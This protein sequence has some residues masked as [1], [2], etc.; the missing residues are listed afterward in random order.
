[1]NQKI[2]YE[3]LERQIARL[4]ARLSRFGRLDEDREVDGISLKNLFELIPIP[5]FYKDSN[6]IYLHCN[7]AFAKTILGIEKDQVE[8]SALRDLT[9]QISPEKA[10]MYYRKDQALLEKAG[11][12]N[13]EAAVKC[14]DG[15]E[16]YYHFY[17]VSY[18]VDDE[19]LGIFGVMLDVSKYKNMLKELDKMNS[20]L[21]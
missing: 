16:R 20:I 12:Q 8:G 11:R 5:F 6:G 17:K 9:D 18:V 7:N 15:V 3:V 4:E 19:I 10:E 2:S 1:M 14:A 13:Y 21:I